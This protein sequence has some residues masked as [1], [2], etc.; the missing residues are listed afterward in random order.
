M[1]AA[2][3]FPSVLGPYAIC[4]SPITVVLWAAGM[5]TFKTLN[6]LV[7]RAK[8]CSMEVSVSNSKIMT[9]SVRT[10]SEPILS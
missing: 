8:A 7:D 3:P 6:R 2:R 4:D 5:V 9:R 1:T 10:T